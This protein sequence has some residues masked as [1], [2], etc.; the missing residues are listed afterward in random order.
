MVSCPLFPLPCVNTTII[1]QYAT[2][3]LVLATRTQLYCHPDLLTP[4]SRTV[5]NTY[6]LFI[7]VLVYSTLQQHLTV[8]SMSLG[9]KMFSLRIRLSKLSVFT[10]MD[11]IAE[12]LLHVLIQEIL[13]MIMSGDCQTLKKEP[14]SYPKLIVQL[15]YP[16]LEITVTENTKC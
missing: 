10:L 16:W 12:I 15:G 6:L 2:R 11:C 7:R 13:I 14:Y 9:N 4:T 8:M 3:K 5:R 1:T